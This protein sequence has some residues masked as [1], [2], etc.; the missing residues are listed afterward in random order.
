MALTIKSITSKVWG[1]NIVK[2]PQVVVEER[3]LVKGSKV[4][5]MYGKN[6]SA[7]VIIPEGIK[8]NDRM[9]ERISILVNETLS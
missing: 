8:L 7:V 2:L 3:E 9:Q 4:T 5:V 1:R 6:Y